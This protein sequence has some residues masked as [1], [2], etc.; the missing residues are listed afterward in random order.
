[1]QYT[2]I[3][4]VV[5]PTKG[6]GKLFYMTAISIPLPGTGAS[7]YWAVST[8]V[9]NPETPEPQ[10]GIV[11]LEGNLYMDDQ[12]YSQWGTNDEYAIDWALQQ[13]G[14]TKAI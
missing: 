5:V 10:P 6:V 11:V 4:D 13:L 7:F 9:E 12:T 1:M 8:E 3:Q 2:V 14:F